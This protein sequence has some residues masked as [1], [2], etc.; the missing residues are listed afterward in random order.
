MKRLFIFALILMAAGCNAGDNTGSQDSVEKILSVDTYNYT[1]Y[2]LHLIDFV[3]VKKKF[4][5]DQAG[6]APSVFFLNAG[7]VE[8]GDGSKASYATGGCCIVWNIPLNEPTKFKVVWNL[9]YDLAAFER[10][11]GDDRAT[12]QS[13]PGTVWCEAIVEVRQPHP[14]KPWHLIFHFFADGTVAAH[15]SAEGNLRSDGPLPL[16]EIKK[17]AAPLPAGQ[18]CLKQ[19]DN[20]WYGIPRKP[21]ME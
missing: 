8:L 6:G 7:F 16:E 17:H 19:I 10:R 4:V 13:A 9:I 21:H 1:K 20:P 18:Y 14:E 15:L 2:E 5:I 11:D 12:K 3:N